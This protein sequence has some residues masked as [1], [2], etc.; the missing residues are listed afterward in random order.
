M[1]KPKDSEKNLMW[2]I[3]E[4]TDGIRKYAFNPD[5]IQYLQLTKANEM[6]YIRLVLAD[7]TSVDL[8]KLKTRKEA[9]EAFNEIVERLA[10]K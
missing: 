3:A 5:Y 4:S 2:A 10:K 1:E 7:G 8:L 9:D 6:Y